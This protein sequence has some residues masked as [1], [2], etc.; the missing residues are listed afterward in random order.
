MLHHA[1]RRREDTKDLQSIAQQLALQPQA[2][3]LSETSPRL[4]GVLEIACVLTSFFGP[5]AWPPHSKSFAYSQIVSTNSTA[6][7]RSNPTHVSLT[8]FIIN[9]SF[10]LCEICRTETSL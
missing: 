5:S 7:S 3:S 9:E 6:A 4:N 8:F 1:Q 2:H 10:R